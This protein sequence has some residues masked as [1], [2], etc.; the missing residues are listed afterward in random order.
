MISASDVVT[1]EMITVRTVLA[2]LRLIALV[3]DL[4]PHFC[5]M[6]MVHNFDIEFLDHY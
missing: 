3:Y 6:V 4:E 1:K 5:N 2:V